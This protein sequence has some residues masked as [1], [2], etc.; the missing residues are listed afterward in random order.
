MNRRAFLLKGSGRGG[1][2]GARGASE[3]H[4]LDGAAGCWPAAHLVPRLAAL[5]ALALGLGDG[6]LDL[7]TRL[8]RV[9]VDEP[10][11]CG[12]GLCRRGDCPVCPLRALQA[13]V[14][15]SWVAAC[16]LVRAQAAANKAT[17]QGRGW[18]AVA[19]VPCLAAPW[20]PDAWFAFGSRQREGSQLER[21]LPLECVSMARLPWSRSQ[22]A[23][24]CAKG[25]PAA[26]QSFCRPGRRGRAR[27]AV[28]PD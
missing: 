19:F 15:C 3:R 6:H 22:S 8:G 24:S 5:V 26:R 21:Q 11:H 25:H 13:A 2:G 28:A 27:S 10:E 4:G 12:S 14:C 9:K 1:R 20:A 23:K 18:H 7:G 16:E 17:H